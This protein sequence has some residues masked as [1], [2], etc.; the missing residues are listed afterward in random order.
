ME[1]NRPVR[2][3]GSAVLG[4]AADVKGKA[5]A[6]DSV[7][8]EDEDGGNSLETVEERG[9]AVL[10]RRDLT[11]PLGGVVVPCSSW[12]AVRGLNYQHTLLASF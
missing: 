11:P 9:R 8:G 10:P 1:A 7:K 4:V 5:V 12:G 2:G 3:W 6:G